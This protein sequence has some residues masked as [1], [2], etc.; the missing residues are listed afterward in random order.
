MFSE[1]PKLMT[2]ISLIK[3]PMTS[4]NSAGVEDNHVQ[5]YACEMCE[6]FSCQSINI[7][8]LVADKLTTEKIF[9]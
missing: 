9:S 3:R 5:S 2:F 1:I 6:G 8:C 4:V 7:T